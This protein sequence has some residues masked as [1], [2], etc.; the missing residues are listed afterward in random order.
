MGIIELIDRDPEAKGRD[1]GPPP[2]QK[3]G[4]AEEAA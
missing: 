2:K 4:G 3:E 1:S